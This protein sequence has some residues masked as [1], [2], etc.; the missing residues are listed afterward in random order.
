M[1][2]K[3]IEQAQAEAEKFFKREDVHEL[4]REA[5][6]LSSCVLPNYQVGKT[7]WE[8]VYDAPHPSKQKRD[9]LQELEKDLFHVACALNR[10]VKTITIKP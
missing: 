6:L 4:F 8:R 10:R 7:L 5:M 2:L 9:E 3:P 1:E